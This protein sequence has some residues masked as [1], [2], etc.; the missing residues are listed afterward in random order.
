VAVL[1][2]GIDYTHEDL[3]ENYRGG[4]DFVFGDDDPFDDGFNS[5]GTHVAGIIGAEQ[6][7]VGVVGVAPEVELFA[8][9]V[10]DGAGFGT[11]EWIIAGIEWAVNNQ[12]DIVNLSIAGPDRQ[13][14]QDACDRAYE[15]GLLLVGA[16]GNSPTGGDPVEYPAAYDSVIAAT[17]TDSLDMAARFSPMGEE[18]E[19]A[20][21]GVDILSTATGASYQLLSGTSQATAHVTGAAALYVLSNAEDLNADGLVNNEDVR[22]MLQLTATDLGN[23]G[24]DGIYGH[25]LVNAAGAAFASETTF[26]VTR[27]S[28]APRL[29][30]EAIRVAGAPYEMTITNLGLKKLALDVFEGAVLRKDLS[31]SFRFGG[32]AP[33]E[34][35]FGLDATGAHYHLLFRPHGNSGTS[36][37]IVLRRGEE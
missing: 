36:A 12:I 1:D 20:A 6:N 29:D 21:P 5:H 2:T 30:G 19:L 4:Y 13:G 37:E 33:Q 25:G 14:L 34:V 22:L 15:A 9:K 3:D 8:V 23:P 17:A 16:A 35:V 32:K 24:K 31:E 27:T 28:G 18:L 11:E 10:L 7:A 26:T